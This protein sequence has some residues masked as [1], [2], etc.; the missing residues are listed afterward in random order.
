MK[1]QVFLKTPLFRGNY[2]EKRDQELDANVVEIH[3]QATTEVSG[4]IDLKVSALFDG[5]GKSVPA[6]FERIFL[7][8]SKVDYYV[9]L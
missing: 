1:V 6:P 5:K 9:A 4:G 3:G 8:L 2:G 7:P